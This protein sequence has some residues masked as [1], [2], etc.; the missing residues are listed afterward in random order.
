MKCSCI[1]KFQGAAKF[2]DCSQTKAGNLFI[3]GSRKAESKSKVKQQSIVG[4]LRKAPEDVVDERRKGISQP[5]IQTKMKSKEEKH[6]VDMQWALWFYECGIPFN[7]AAARQFQI[8]V[9][10]TA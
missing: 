2:R 4:M 1:S 7:A 10:A 9:E 3:Q 8:A 6:Y 5:T